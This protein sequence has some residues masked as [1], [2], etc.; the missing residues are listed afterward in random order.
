MALESVLLACAT[1]SVVVLGVGLLCLV[2]FLP[3]I[4]FW[5]LVRVVVKCKHTMVE[6]AAAAAPSLSSIIF[7][8]WEC[9]LLTT[10]LVIVI[11]VLQLVHIRLLWSST[12]YLA[13]FRW[14]FLPIRNLVMPL[15]MFTAKLGM[16]REGVPTH[17]LDVTVDGDVD[18]DVDGGEVYL[19]YGSEN[20]NNHSSNNHNEIPPSNSSTATP[21]LLLDKNSPQNPPQRRPIQKQQ[22][23]GKIRRRYQQMQRAFMRDGIQ[24]EAFYS[25]TALNLQQ[26]VPIL[27][28]HQCRICTED[29]TKNRWEEFLERFLVVT[30]VPNGILDYY[31]TSTTNSTTN[32]SSGEN[33]ELVAFQLSVQQGR[34]WHW[35]MY[36][37][38]TSATKSGIWFHGIGTNMERARRLPHVE[39]CHGHVHQTKSKQNAG[40]STTAELTD[41]EVLLSKLYPM[42]FT[43]HP[44]KQIL[45]VSLWQPEQHGTGTDGRS[46]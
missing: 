19:L 2:S 5:I 33:K 26:V 15:V 43:R 11:V 24:H 16:M 6:P 29:T 13:F 22:S 44:P 35:F 7:L 30:V 41:C 3:S 39:Y 37:S 42:S 40:F 8:S 36:F 10:I 17:Y 34:V 14:L 23:G 25:D 18:C 4:S 12:G 1:L 38:K 21:L 9:W 45:E 32:G 27:W 31:Y 20:S 28:E 46:D